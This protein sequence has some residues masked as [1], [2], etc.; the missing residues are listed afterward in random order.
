MKTLN[1]VLAEVQALATVAED[2]FEADLA[3]VVADLRA[4]VAGSPAPV[5]DPVV[6]VAVTTQSG[7]V[8][9]FVPKV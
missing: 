4:L 5:A 6:S 1:D 2:Q 9:E 3:T 8:S 7:A